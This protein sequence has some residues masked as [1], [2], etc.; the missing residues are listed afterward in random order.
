MRSELEQLDIIDRYL[1]GKMSADQAATF[2]QQMNADPAL[3]S[4]VKDQEILIQT[5]S[6]KAMLT[7]INTIAG[8]SAAGAAG[9]GIIQW[10]ITGVTV[11]GLTVAG[12][13]IFNAQDDSN[14]SDTN[15]ELA[16]VTEDG[17]ELTISPDTGEIFTMELAISE[18]DDL[19]ELEVFNTPTDPSDDVGAENNNGNDGALIPLYVPA[20][21]DN[22]E[23]GTKV[24]PDELA[25]Y[26]ES[27]YQSSLVKNRK[28]SFDGGHLAMQKWFDKNLMY[29]GTAKKERV[30]GTVKVT[31]FV[32]A[33]GNL[34]HLNAD[35]FILKDDEGRPLYGLKRAKH[36]K[37]IRAF[38]T[39]AKN[40]FDKCPLWLPATNTNGTAIVSEQVWYVNFVLDGKSSVYQL[41]DETGYIEEF[42]PTI[43]DQEAQIH[44]TPNNRRKRR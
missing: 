16:N 32:E 3:K 25:E 5:V 43:G 36:K 31:F 21:P 13:A 6:R 34:T 28:A 18:D 4:M 29:S 38:E 27:D 17:T 19:E 24:D 42:E 33:G 37:A 8:L 22:S 39:N 2:E 41:E 23:N 15:S 14:Q 35:C 11:V 20:R 10:I 7:E 9:W 1:D 30:Q 44:L 12:V 40:A 26:D